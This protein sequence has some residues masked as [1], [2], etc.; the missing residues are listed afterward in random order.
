M[1]IFGV[2]EVPEKLHLSSAVDGHQVCLGRLAVDSGIWPRE[3]LVAVVHVVT[4]AAV[5]DPHWQ[6]FPITRGG[7][8]WE[9]L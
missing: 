4:I 8:G 7:R 2:V 6:T 1:V 9:C 3:A 5:G